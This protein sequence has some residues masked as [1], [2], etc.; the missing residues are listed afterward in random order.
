VAE[1]ALGLLHNL[2]LDAD[3]RAAVLALGGGK[4]AGG[5]DATGDKAGGSKGGKSGKGGTAAA[6]AA[7]EGEEAGSPTDAVRA[8]CAALG[9]HATHAGAQRAGCAALCS[10]A[11]TGD[12]AVCARIKAAGGVRLAR[13]ALRRFHPDDAAVATAAKAALRALTAA[14]VPERDK[15]DAAARE[16]ERDDPTAALPPSPDGGKLVELH[17]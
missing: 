5:G 6:A 12:R 10:L 14:L 2:S 16:R 13:A 3:A 15:G 4:I 7:G 1:V 11:A 17:V 8:I 9:A